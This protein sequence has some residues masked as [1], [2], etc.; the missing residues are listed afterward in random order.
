VEICDPVFRDG[1][2]MFLIHVLDSC[3]LTVGPSANE[4]AVR[5]CMGMGG[6]RRAG[7]AGFRRSRLRLERFPFGAR[8]LGGL[9]G[10]QTEMSRTCVE[11][12]NDNGRP[13]DRIARVAK[14]LLAQIQL[15][16]Q[17]VVFG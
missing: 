2:G 9:P 5:G 17:F 4:D 13:A 1:D 6:A 8:N 3:F 12:L 14:A 11:C 10:R 7:R 15:L 16:Q